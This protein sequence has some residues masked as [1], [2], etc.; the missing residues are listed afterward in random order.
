MNDDK[1]LG[2]LKEALMP[3]PVKDAEKELG[4]LYRIDINLKTGSSF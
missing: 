1:E 3:M 4:K 2:A